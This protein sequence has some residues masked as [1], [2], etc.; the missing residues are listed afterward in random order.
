MKRK[1]IE[2]QRL[3]ISSAHVDELMGKDPILTP[4]QL[5]ILLFA[6]VERV[7]N[8]ERELHGELTDIVGKPF[9]RTARKEI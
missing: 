1:K 6:T 2:Q 8:L 5:T 7:A 9:E 3:A 4:R